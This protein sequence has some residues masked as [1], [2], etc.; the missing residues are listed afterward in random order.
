MKLSI[1][2]DWK[3]SLWRDYSKKSDCL[4]VI[5]V[6]DREVEILKNWWTIE[7]WAITENPRYTSEKMSNQKK[8]AIEKILTISDQLNLIAEVLNTITEPEPDLEIIANAKSKFAEIKE[9]LNN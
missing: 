6:N 7:D 4:E 9:I 5:D 1:F 3:F 2:K 8:V